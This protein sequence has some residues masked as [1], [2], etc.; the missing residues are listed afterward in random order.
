MKVQLLLGSSEFWTRL[1]QDLSEARHVAYLQTLS[2]EGDRVG[3]RIGRALERCSAADR[4]LLVD[5][6][7][8]L[9]HSDRVIPG[10]AW[11]DRALRTEVAITHRWVRRLE[12]AGV[13]VRFCNPLGPS[14][15]RKSTRLNSSHVRTSRMPSSA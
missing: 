8:L 1:K 11:M 9:Y 4:R 13:G 2:F 15:D 3:T 7:S 14:P 10:I 12:R 6:Y 5:G